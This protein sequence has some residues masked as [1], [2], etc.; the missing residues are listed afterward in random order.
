MFI[1]RT[2]QRRVRSGIYREAEPKDIGLAILCL[3][4]FI[5]HLMFN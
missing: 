5:I 1:H 3:G 2:K 4:L